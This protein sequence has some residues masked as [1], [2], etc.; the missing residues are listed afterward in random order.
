MP[1]RNRQQE[2]GA[3]LVE[4]VVSSIFWV[5]LL[6]GTLVI[7]LTL[8]RAI[9]VTQVCRDTA[10]MYAYGVDFSQSSNQN[11][12]IN[13][14]QGLNMSTSGGNGVIILSTLTY[15]DSTACAAGG[16]TTSN[17]PNYQYVVFTKRITFG[18]TAVYTSTFG[19]PSASIISSTGDI[20]TQNYLTD[21]SVRATNFSPNVMTVNTAGQ[22]VYMAEMYVSSP[23]LNW[24]AFIGTPGAYSRAI[25]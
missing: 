15:I 11:L 3:A 1:L 6:L 14:S 17:C 22:Y 7:G 12:I 25:F 20:S 24:W 10:H 18:N 2:R 23:D 5:P 13:E 21:P 9:Q 8:I 4:F 19:S 16:Y